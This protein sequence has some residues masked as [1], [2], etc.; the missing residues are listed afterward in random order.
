MAAPANRSSQPRSIAELWARAEALAGQTLGEVARDQGVA[1]PPDMRRHKGVVGELCERV[2][3]A[4]A[5][6]RAEPD[7]P[8][9]GVEL[10][11]LPVDPSGR[12][13]ESTFVCSIPPGEIGD[14]EWEHCRVRRKLAHV[15][16]I[17]IEGVRQIPLHRRRIGSPLLWTPSPEEEA[18]LRFDWEELAGLIGRGQHDAISGHLGK[19]LQIRPKAANSHARRR[20]FDEDGG[21]IDAMPRGFYLRAT[22]TARLIAESFVTL[23]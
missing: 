22:F 15:L 9:L 14:V 13:L 16:W 21:L 19:W 12:P 6:S 5:G 11:T 2:L 18:Q 8:D 4:S 23:R 10:K 17:P 7:F 1:L 3:G 20:A